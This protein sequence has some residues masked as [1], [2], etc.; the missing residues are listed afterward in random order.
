MHGAL[1]WKVFNTAVEMKTIIRQSSDQQQLKNVLNAL[2]T[3]TAN[4]DDTHW[5][6]QFQ[7]QTLTERYGREVMAHFEEEALYVFPSHDM[8]WEHNKQKLLAANDHYPIAKITADCQ[9][10][11]AKSSSAENSGGLIRV[12][13]MCVSQSK[14]YV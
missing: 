7:W 3:S 4:E 9:G 12:L 2:R 10:I 1:I 11:H 13:H 14:P 6:Q 8:E 5:L